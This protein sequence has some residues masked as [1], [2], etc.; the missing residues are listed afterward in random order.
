M[1]RCCRARAYRHRA[2]EIMTPEIC[3]IMFCRKLNFWYSADHPVVDAS[4]LLSGADDITCQGN[5][6]TQATEADRLTYFRSDSMF[7]GR[8]AFGS[9]TSTGYRRL[10]GPSSKLYRHQIFSCYYKDGVAATFDTYNIISNDDS[11]GYG[12]PRICGNSANA[13]LLNSST[14]TT[15]LS[16]G[17]AAQSATVLPMPATVCVASGNATFDIRIG[18]PQLATVKDRVW[19]GAFRHFVGVNV[20]LTAREIAIIEGVIAWSDGTQHRLTDSHPF[21]LRPPLVGD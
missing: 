13:T 12:Q 17:G 1:A 21:R 19:Q 9:T 2:G 7:G 14:Y 5:N 20:V 6:G 16:K 8:P 18:G 4:G 15:T 3:A 10:V 11:A